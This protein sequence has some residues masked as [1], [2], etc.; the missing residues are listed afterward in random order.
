MKT[1]SLFEAGQSHSS[2]C[3]GST[4]QQRAACCPF[5]PFGYTL[6]VAA[7]QEELHSAEVRPCECIFLL[8]D[9]VLMPLAN[10]YMM[11]THLIVK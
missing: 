7:L 6:P 5:A 4:S 8:L 3:G 10:S 9:S 11:D 1:L 2:C